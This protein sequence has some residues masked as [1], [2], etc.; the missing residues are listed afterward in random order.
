MIQSLGECNLLIKYGRIELYGHVSSLKQCFTRSCTYNIITDSIGYRNISTIRHPLVQDPFPAIL[1]PSSKVG[2]K[3]TRKIKEGWELH[4]TV[5]YT[6]K[7]R[8]CQL[9]N[10]KIN[11]SQLQ[12]FVSKEQQRHT[13]KMTMF[14][15][16]KSWM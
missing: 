7:E 4:L 16:K 15:K 3:K 5:G 11:L 1:N 13:L 10:Q 6:F 2:W 9:I 8:L 12:H 14:K